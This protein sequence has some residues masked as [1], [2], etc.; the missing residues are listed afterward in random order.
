MTD[1]SKFG[2]HKHGAEKVMINPLAD[3]VSDVVN[4]LLK[5]HQSATDYL[6]M[7]VMALTVHR[8]GGTNMV[9]PCKKCLLDTALQFR[10]I[11]SMIEEL[12]NGK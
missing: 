7:I 2:L 5:E 11:G 3:N 12:A 6:D 4:R 8:L 10:D 1:Q 9:F